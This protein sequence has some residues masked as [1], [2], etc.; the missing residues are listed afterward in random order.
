MPGKGTSNLG[1]FFVTVS[2]AGGR[3]DPRLFV[4][5]GV[6][7]R[8]GRDGGGEPGFYGAAHGG[9]SELEGF[10]DFAVL[11]RLL[12]VGFEVPG[13]EHFGGWLAHDVQSWDP[14]RV[15]NLDT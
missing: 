14:T 5:Y 9:F 4:G 11:G 13:V 1:S 2:P 6:G 8:W 12:G 15:L 10:G 7:E 3:G